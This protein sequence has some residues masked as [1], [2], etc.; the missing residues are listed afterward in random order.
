[1]IE[2]IAGE[3]MVYQPITI[4]EID[5]RGMRIEATFALQ[6]DSLREFR[7]MLA[8]R[9]VVLK[10][11]VARCEIGEL[12]D[13]VVMYRCHVE[14]IDPPR[15]ALAALHEFLAVHNS[16]PPPIVDAELAED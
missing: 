6:N 12:R 7:L 3:V 14:F 8:T 5:E 11:R 15:H 13:G 16:P 1:M 10:G 2:R 9:S 4:L